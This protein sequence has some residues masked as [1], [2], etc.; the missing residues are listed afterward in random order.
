MSPVLPASYPFNACLTPH[1]FTGLPRFLYGRI[2]QIRTGAS[3]LAAHISWKN[4]DTSTLFPFCEE[5]DET[6]HHDILHSSAKAQ[7]HLTHLSGVDDIGPNTPIWLWFLPP[8]SVSR[9]SLCHSHSFPCSYPACSGQYYCSWSSIRLRHFSLI[10]ISLARLWL[11]R[12]QYLNSLALLSFSGQCVSAI[13]FL[14]FCVSAAV[15]IWG[16]GDFSTSDDCF[17]CDWQWAFPL[18]FIC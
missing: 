8:Y 11:S 5:D 15:D 18:R 3:H 6:F 4:R 13:C 14:C 7:P 2:H 1:A 10:Q 9:V 16:L 12:Y 17:S